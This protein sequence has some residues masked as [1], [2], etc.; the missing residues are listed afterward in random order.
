M[1]PG[2]SKLPG[3]SESITVPVEE[4]LERVE[5]GRPESGRPTN[6]LGLVSS[7]NTLSE[8]ALPMLWNCSKK[9]FLAAISQQL[10]LAQVASE[11]LTQIHPSAVYNAV[12]CV[13]WF[14]PCYTV[15]IFSQGCCTPRLPCWLPSG[16]PASC[17]GC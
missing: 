17:L 7:Q 13:V 9:V 4:G 6:R 14:Y 2:R 8:P 5:N 11:A 16:Q 1:G 10:G 12:W 3:K 15:L